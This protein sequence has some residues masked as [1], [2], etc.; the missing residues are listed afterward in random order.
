MSSPA[1][2]ALISAAVTLVIVLAIVVL[3][4]VGLRIV[5]SV[6]QRRTRSDGAHVTGGLR[7]S[8]LRMATDAAQR[9]LVGFGAGLFAAGADT[10]RSMAR[11]RPATGASEHG[12]L[13]DRY[14]KAA[15][16][17]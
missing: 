13:E 10:A 12:E 17:L 1:G 11:S 6:S 8:R 7:A 3:A 9:R 2:S 16:D 5:L 4:G 15:E 14:V